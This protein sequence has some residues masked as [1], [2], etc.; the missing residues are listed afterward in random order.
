MFLAFGFAPLFLSSVWFRALFGSIFL[1]FFVAVMA[2]AIPVALCRSLWWFSLKE[3]LP[4]RRVFFPDVS[5]RIMSA[6][7]FWKREEEEEEEW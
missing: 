2:R 7:I 6:S 1:L 4:A 5:R 3:G